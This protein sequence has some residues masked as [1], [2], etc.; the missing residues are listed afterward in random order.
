[1]LVFFT[2]HKSFLVA[3]APFVIIGTYLLLA[4]YRLT[5]PAIHYDEALYVNAALGGIDDTTFIAARIGELPTLTMPYIGALKSWLYAPVFALFGV[6]PITMRLPFIL[7]SAGI[8]YLLFRILRPRIGTALSLCV[9]LATAIN[10][11]FIIFTRLDFGPV[12]L[13]LL[14][15]LLAAWLLLR[16]IQAPRSRELALFWVVM[17]V[18]EFNKINFLWYVAAF[19]IAA[20]AAYG[21]PLIAKLRPIHGIIT[22][23]G[24]SWCVGYYLYITTTFQFTSN[25][26]FV[27]FDLML[28]NLQT[29]VGGNWLYNYAFAATSLGLPGV[30]WMMAGVIAAGGILLA[31]RWRP[32][33]VDD[34]TVRLFTFF[35]IFICVLLLQLA[36]TKAATAG[37]HYFSIIPF[38][39]ILFVLG[40][41][42]IC[43]KIWPSRRRLALAIA[44]LL[45]SILSSYNLI[46]YGAYAEAY[47]KS[48]LNST[49]SPA[50]YKL[51]DFTKSHTS[52]KFASLDWGIHVQLLALDPVRG[53]YY[54][55]FAP[56]DP[57]NPEHSAFVY[58]NYLSDFENTFYITRT[59]SQQEAKDLPIA[60]LKIAE[61]HGLKIQEQYYFDDGSQDVYSIFKLGR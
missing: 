38:W 14:L 2:A 40:L 8:L 32:K 7:L 4:I 30:F 22:I 16:F 6:D 23:L 45:V 11:S 39:Q 27:G 35:A 3:A 33:Q 24:L 20:F 61:Q 15:K 34:A 31:P 44:A 48:T 37:W 28:V 42:V 5:F 41:Y 19:G 13:D 46:V 53:K 55:V 1:M 25:L 10:A 60:F 47:G 54:E 49:W 58:K 9:L 56:I 57:N 51:V 50:L 59:P 26:S 29:I 52:I 18:G 21:K 43:L 17:A 12:V 36:I